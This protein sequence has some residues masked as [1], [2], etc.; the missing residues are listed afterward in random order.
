MRKVYLSGEEGGGVIWLGYWGRD[1]GDGV[2]MMKVC[3]SGEEGAE[4]RGVFATVWVME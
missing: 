3:L 2:R 4:G 1:G